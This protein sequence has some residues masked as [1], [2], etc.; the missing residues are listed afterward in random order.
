[1]Y[2]GTCGFY[3]SILANAYPMSFHNINKSNFWNIQFNKYTYTLNS[4]WVAFNLL[5]LAFLLSVWKVLECS[6][7]YMY[8][9]VWLVF[10]SYYAPFSPIHTYS[11]ALLDAIYN[12]LFIIKIK[13]LLCFLFHQIF[14]WMLTTHKHHLLDFFEF[15]RAELYH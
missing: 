12:C 11:C 1:M 2:T 10:G 15:W 6:F 3:I 13:Y 8:T 9:Y 7:D 5:P 4:N 14:L